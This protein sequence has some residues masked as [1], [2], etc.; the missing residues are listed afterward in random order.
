MKRYLTSLFIRKMKIETIT[1]YY[2]TFA[3]MTKIKNP[4]NTAHWHKCRGLS[5][6]AGGKETSTT[7]LGKHLA[8]GSKAKFC[9]SY[10]HAIQFQLCWKNEYICPSNIIAHVPNN[11]KIKV[12]Q[13]PIK[14]R[15]VYPQSR[16][17]HSNKK[18]GKTRLWGEKWEWW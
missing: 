9:L 7:S 12:K 17:L 15:I 18:T 13:I 16:I 3:R 1:R 11:W 10:Q 6:I 14:R 2:Y 4:D 5:H 8:A